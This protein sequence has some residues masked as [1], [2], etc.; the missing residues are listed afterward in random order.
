M[1]T[2]GK[3]ITQSFFLN[4]DGFFALKKRWK[5]RLVQDVKNKLEFKNLQRKGDYWEACVLSRTFLT[6]GDHLAY[7]M[8]RGRDFT[9]GFASK[10]GVDDARNNGC[11]LEV[12]KDI[13]TKDADKIL[14]K[15]YTPEGYKEIEECHLVIA[16]SEEISQES[17]KLSKPATPVRKLGDFF[18]QILKPI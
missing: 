11:D 16:L 13:L 10:Y 8:L 17:S 9:K 18:R 2:I 1:R 4:E 7:A 15:L 14:I 5:E 3:K 12:Y 6:S